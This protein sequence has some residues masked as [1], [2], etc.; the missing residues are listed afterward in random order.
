MLLLS[1]SHVVALLTGLLEEV[2]QEIQAEGGSDMM[3]TA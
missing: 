3:L 1:M 2:L